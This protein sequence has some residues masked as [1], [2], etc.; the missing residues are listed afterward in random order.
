M[1]Q[2][3]LPY[4]AHWPI[5]T[6]KDKLASWFKHYAEAMELN[7]WTSSTIQGGATYDE[8]SQTWTT[9]VVREGHQPR[10]M[11]VKHLVLATGFSGEAR[12]PKFEG[13]ETFKGPMPHSSKHKGAEGWEGKKAIVVGCCNSGHDI[14]AQFY[15]YGADT[16]IVQRSSTYVVSSKHGLPAWLNGF[17]QEGGPPIDDADILFTSLPTEL[18]AEFH[19]ISTAKVEQLDKDIL[20]GLEKAGFKLNRYNSGL[21]MKVCNSTLTGTM[22]VL[23]R[24]TIV[25]PRRRRLLPGCGVLAANCR[26]QDQGETG[27]RNQAHHGERHRICRWRLPRGRHYCPGYRIRLHARHRPQSCGP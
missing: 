6:P 1:D 16:T 24:G 23:T 27:S 25:L 14:A 21:F 9:T 11:K 18:V 22:T 26:W 12:M 15:E 19:K 2:P 13:M 5:F 7:V 10:E 20:D 8:K 17:Y 4:P 3:Y